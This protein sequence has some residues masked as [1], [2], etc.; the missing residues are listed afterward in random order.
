MKQFFVLV[1][2]FLCFSTYVNA[3]DL[4]I[5]INKKGKIGYV[6]SQ[7][8]V[9]IPFKYDNA[10]PFKRGL[11]KVAKGK[12]YGMI[13]QKN[14]KVIP[15][16]FDAIEEWGD[17]L[18]LVTK[19]KKK[20]LYDS[21]GQKI[22]GADYSYISDLNCYGKAW[23]AKGGKIKSAKGRPCVYDGKIGIINKYGNF[24]IKP[25]Y[26]GIYEFSIKDESSDNIWG[27]GTSLEF[28][29]YYINDTLKTSCDYVGYSKNGYSIMGAGI[30][31]GKGNILLKYNKYNSV[32]MPHS[33]MVRFYDLKRKKTVCG[34]Y[35]LAREKEHEVL[36]V[37]SPYKEIDYAPISDFAGR[38]AYVQD[39]KNGYFINRS[40]EKIIEGITS[41]FYGEQAKLWVAMSD[42]VCKVYDVD[43]HEKFAGKGFVDIVLP[44]TKEV[45]PVYCVKKNSKWGVVDN[46]G[47]NITEFMYDNVN[48]PCNRFIA[49]S[50]DGKW[51]FIDEQGKMVI[52]CKFKNMSV[53]LFSDQ[54]YIWVQCD[55]NLYHNYV[56]AEDKIF[57]NG[58]EDYSFIQSNREYSWV[59]PVNFKVE[60]NALNRILAGCKL[61]DDSENAY[62][63]KAAVQDKSSN[64]SLFA[65]KVKDFGCIINAKGDVYFSLPIPKTHYEKVLNALLEKY[66]RPLDACEMKRLL[67]EVTEDER[68]YHIRSVI[69]EENW[70]F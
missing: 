27:Q 34:Y 29:S 16:Q 42:G 38:V 8:D 25:S 28:N 47:N 6:N 18:F 48:A 9:V 66:N 69:G 54:K 46:N 11:A 30:M 21:N 45:S 19:G 41:A 65:E 49:V 22:L 59:R 55:D 10:Y 52:P 44:K 43:G 32:M 39:G 60:D 13:N 23:C 57:E 14:K 63:S 15:F 62:Q 20:G 36:V 4:S 51:G 7:G 58:Y 68:S 5:K 53:P 64:D 67:L 31:D 40:G 24:L 33:D 50:Q 3:Q 17:D 26:K 61:F 12:K 56:I 35:D 70:D 37:R 2:I 1:G